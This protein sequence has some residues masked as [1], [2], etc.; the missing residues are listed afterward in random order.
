[1]LIRRLIIFL[2]LSFLTLTGFTQDKNVKI[3]KVPELLELTTQEDA[4]PRVVNFWATWCKPCIKELPYFIEAAKNNPNIEF[5]FVSLDFADQIDKVN[6]FTA[7]KGMHPYSLYL[8]DDLDYN[9]WIDKVSSEW[10][11]AIPFTILIDSKGK[12][13]FEKEFEEG[14]LT[15]L[16]NST[17]KI[18]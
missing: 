15:T 5:I 13:V 12:K 14:E 18:K 4:T 6:A 9:A 10:S 2:F 17:F 1:M 8:I 16:I 11:G 3:I 7:K